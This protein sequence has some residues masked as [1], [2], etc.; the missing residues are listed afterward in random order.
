MEGMRQRAPCFQGPDLDSGVLA[1]SD[2][3]EELPSRSEEAAV[4][5]KFVFPHALD[6]RCLADASK[7]DEQS[8]EEDEDTDGPVSGY[9]GQSL[10]ESKM[11]TDPEERE[12]WKSRGWRAAQCCGGALL[13]LA[14][15]FDELD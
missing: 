8:E 4:H 2:R 10:L 9:L 12:K 13:V 11:F 15:I 1:K 14:L 3:R 7:S 5:Y 6:S